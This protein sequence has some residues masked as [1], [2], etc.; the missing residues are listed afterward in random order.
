MEV[1]FG[2]NGVIPNVYFF[3][4]CRSVSSWIFGKVAFRLNDGF[5]I[6]KSEVLAIERRKIDQSGVLGGSLIE[7]ANQNRQLF[8]SRLHNGTLV[9]KK[10]RH[11][12]MAS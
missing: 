1:A 10:S 5:S 11:I 3:P 12:C 4:V 6:G 7:V 9:S 2:T 8:D